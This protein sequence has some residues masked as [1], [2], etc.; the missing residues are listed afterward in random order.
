MRIRC[1]HSEKPAFIKDYFLKRIVFSLLRVANAKKSYCTESA[2]D[3]IS[4][5]HRDP[6]SATCSTCSTDSTWAF[7]L[8]L[9]RA[10]TASLS[11][12]PK[13]SSLKMGRGW[14][15]DIGWFCSAALTEGYS[16]LYEVTL[17]TKSRERGR[18]RR[19]RRGSLLLNTAV[20]PENHYIYWGPASQDMDKHCLWMDFFFFFHH[21]FTLLSSFEERE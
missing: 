2:W 20:L 12:S 6:C 19:R 17:R 3:G 13:D 15:G 1:L 16:I 18:R 10:G 14:G 7:Y 8:L 9:S 21:T 11:S 5:P 4:F